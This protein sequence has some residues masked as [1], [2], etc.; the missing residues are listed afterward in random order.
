L[1]NNKF[2]FEGKSSDE[3]VFSTY[4]STKRTSAMNKIFFIENENIIM[5]ITIENKKINDTEFDWII[6]NS[7]SGTKTSLI[8]KE[9]EDFIIKHQ[10]D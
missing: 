4:F 3:V 1:F 5:D 6:I 2:H 9:Y 7:I 8:E 10:K